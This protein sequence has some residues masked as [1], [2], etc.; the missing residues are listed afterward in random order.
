MSQH[1]PNNRSAGQYP[2]H[3]AV[4]QK[5]T[6]QPSGTPE[7]WA[8]YPY[9][10]QQSPSAPQ[11]PGQS[12]YRYPS[13][14]S[15]YQTSQQTP[16]PNAYSGTGSNQQFWPTGYSNPQ[17]KPKGASTLL[18]LG[19][20]VAILSV[21]AVAAFI[22]LRFV[23]QGKMKLS[24]PN[25]LS[26]QQKTT[27]LGQAENLNP[28][29]FPMVTSTPGRVEPGV[30]TSQEQHANPNEPLTVPSN[31]SPLP[32]TT[33]VPPSS[34]LQSTQPSYMYESYASV[35]SYKTPTSPTKPATHSCPASMLKKGDYAFVN[36][37]YGGTTLRDG[38]F[39]V[40][41]GHA[42]DK[43]YPGA[44][45]EVLEGPKCDAGVNMFE[46]KTS[47]DTVFWGPEANHVGSEWWMLPIHSRQVCQGAKP[48]RLLVGMKAFV[49][50]FPDD[51]VEVYPEPRLDTDYFYQIQ[52]TQ[53]DVL[54]SVRQKTEIFDLLKG[55]H[56]DGKGAN[57]WY[58]RLQNGKEGWIRESGP[59]HDYYYIGPYYD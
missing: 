39:G 56:C 26:K 47:W 18:I 1:N 21:V 54:K 8:Q 14:Q 6:G 55:P 5:N 52:P 28:N 12:T 33:Q 48:T 20:I 25:T 42:G 17:V 7:Q 46:L 40:I 36:P 37:V 19:A 57:W 9:S 3:H 27:P 41:A 32:I 59:A 10:P 58:V 30:D 50:E 45:F 31:T 44:I 16:P 34:A 49:L 23:R 22:G 53:H 51:P 11:Y 2:P 24:I 15:T 38:P 13:Q 35:D 43:A 4:G 29:F